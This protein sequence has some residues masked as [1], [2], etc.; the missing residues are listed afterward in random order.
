MIPVILSGGSGTRLWPLSRAAYPKQFLSLVSDK[1]LFQE[2]ILRFEKCL[3]GKSNPIIIGNQ[4]H[5]FLLAEQCRLID[6]K[7][8]AI[9]LEPFGRNTAAAITSACLQA[10]ENDEDALLLVMPADHVIDDASALK[11]AIQEGKVLAD[12]G[13]IVTFGI[14]PTHAET[15]YGYI[16][17][18]ENGGGAQPV[19]GFVEKPD[20]ETAQ[21]YVDDGCYYWNSGIFLF[22]A[23]VMLNELDKFAPTVLQTISAAMNSCFH[24]LDFKRLNTD[25][26]SKVPDISVDYAVMEKSSIVSVVPLNSGWSDIGSWSSVWSISEKNNDGNV[27]SGNTVTHEV[28]NSFIHSSSRLVTAL[29]VEDLIVVETSDAVMITTKE[30]SQDVKKLVDAAKKEGKPEAEIHRQVYRPWGHYDSIDQGDRYQVKRIRVAPGQKLSVQMHHHRAEH[31]VVVAGTAKVSIN[32][33][34]QL[35]TENQSIYIPI[36]SIHALE[37]PGRI[38]LEMIEIQSGA[39]LGEDDI[40]RFED[41]YGRAS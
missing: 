25:E 32:G 13:Q 4:E 11:A 17:V 26:F 8:A 1:T 29:G 9:I 10:R 28:K 16:C 36:G 41:R 23:S 18:Q 35:L 31:W 37:N 15:G 6:V 12:S 39:Y 19:K 2:T 24:D 22:K 27:L 7:P 20:K 3:E 14:V 30:R 33:K 34:E 38:P 5:R 21:R 40:F